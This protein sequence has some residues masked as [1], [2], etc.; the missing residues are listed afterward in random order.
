VRIARTR[1]IVACVLVASLGIFF[2]I[3]IVRRGPSKT[4]RSRRGLRAVI[5][6][7]KAVRQFPVEKY[8]KSGDSFIYHISDRRDGF[9]RCR[10]QIDTVGG[11]LNDWK[12]AFREYLKARGECTGHKWRGSR[13]PMLF[14]WKGSADSHGWVIFKGPADGL[15]ITFEYYQPGLVRRLLGTRF[16][17]F[18]AFLLAKIGYPLDAITQVT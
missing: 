13:E 9:R 7:P 18:L 17:K 1:I 8:V 10:L 14:R 4:V 5:L 15:S 11:D 16:G 12:D 3:R 2:F 6:M